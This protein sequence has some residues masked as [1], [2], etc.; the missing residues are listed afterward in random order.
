MKFTKSVLAAALM[1]ASVFSVSAA[2]NA[3][4]AADVQDKVIVAHRG[5]SAYLPEH[6][7]ESKALA[8][9]MGVKY[10]EQDLAMTKDDRLVVVHDHFLDRVTDVAEKFPNRARKDGRYYVIDFT[11]D[12]IKTL[13]FTEGFEI[14]DGKRVQGYPN[15]F[16]MFT[17]VFKIHTLEE[18]IEFIQGLNKTMGRDI[19]LYVETK[20]PW[21]HKQEGKDI[22]KATL[23]VLKKYGYTTKD[24]N[25]IFQTFDYPDLK[26]VVDTLMPKMGMK[27]KTVMLLGYNDW[28]ETYELKD[29]K[30]VPFDFNYLLDPKNFPEVSKYA[31]GLGPT[32]AMLFDLEKT[33]KGNIVVNDFVKNAHLNGMM[34]HPYTVRADALPEY[35]SNVDEL[36]KAILI[37]AD[38]DGVFTDFPDLGVAF[39]EKQAKK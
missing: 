14:K 9:T 18:E 3:A 5:A 28:N 36:F 26:Y 6:T 4:Y 1:T 11:L 22:S 16:P 30:W 13:N 37:D 19:G 23:E 15:R 17:S 2:V 38:A 34:V 20:A 10:I 35:A 31:T 8:Y 7:L 12:E 21:F 25:V 29:G 32:Y 24:S 39:L 27:L 33:K